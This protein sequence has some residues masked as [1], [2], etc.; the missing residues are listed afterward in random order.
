MSWLS[1]H[2][3]DVLDVASVVATVLAAWLAWLAIRLSG[4][5][6][7]ASA[8][9][10]VRE[11]R[12]DFELD[13][14]TVLDDAV[15]KGP[16]VGFSDLTVQRCLRLLPQRELPRI[17]AL[18]GVDAPDDALADLQAIRDATAPGDFRSDPYK[19][20]EDGRTYLDAMRNELHDAIRRRLEERG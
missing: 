20:L 12:I 18:Y 13:H 15:E 9:A 7:E 10:L 8:K 17:R 1:A 19:E 3:H 16:N 14:L 2:W 11:R 6:S 5:Q 4:R